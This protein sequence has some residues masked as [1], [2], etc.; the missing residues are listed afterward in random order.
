MRGKRQATAPAGCRVRLAVNGY[1]DEAFRSSNVRNSY[2]F[3]NATGASFGTAGAAW[4]F[5]ATPQTGAITAGEKSYTISYDYV[6]RYNDSTTAPGITQG[7][8]LGGS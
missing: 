1:M 7:T 3:G 4:G 8:V 5:S 6:I 2:N